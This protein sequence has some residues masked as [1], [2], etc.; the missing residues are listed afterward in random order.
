VEDNISYIGNHT[1][2]VG[3]IYITLQ[4]SLL[5]FLKRRN[6]MSK[7]K[8]T[9]QLTRNKKISY[10]LYTQTVLC[11]IALR[12]GLGSVLGSPYV[13][14]EENYTGVLQ[15]LQFSQQLTFHQCSI[16]IHHNPPGV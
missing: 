2:A 1:S 16:F 5:Q 13:I 14:S 11:A 7:H 12:S 10:Y 6:D 15:F 9:S 4:H 8:V 3:E